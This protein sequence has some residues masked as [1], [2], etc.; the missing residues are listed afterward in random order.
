MYGL[1]TRAASAIA[2]DYISQLSGV[3]LIISEMSLF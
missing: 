1:R 2:L 3:A